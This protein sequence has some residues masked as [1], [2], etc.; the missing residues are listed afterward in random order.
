MAARPDRT[1]LLGRS[2][3]RTLVIAGDA[4]PLIPRADSDAMAAAI[5]NGKALVI[6][7]TAHLSNLERPAQFNEAV[8]GFVTAG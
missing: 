2:G 4:D 5:P 3:V 7:N 1:A 8:I 6:P